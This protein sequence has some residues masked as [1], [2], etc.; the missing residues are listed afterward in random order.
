MAHPMTNEKYLPLLAQNP[1]FVDLSDQVHAELLAAAVRRTY[2]S[3][4]LIVRQ[5][6][7]AYAFHLLVEGKAKL[8]QVTANGHQVLVR[9]IVPGQ[10]TGVISVLSGFTY[11]LSIQPIGTCTTLMWPGELLAQFIERYPRIGFNAL[12]IMVI[13]NQQRQQRYQELLT[14]RVEQR[15]AQSLLRLAE[16]VGRPEGDRILLDLPLSRED[17][18]EYTGTTLFTVSRILRQWEEQGF[19]QSGRERVCLCNLPALQSIANPAPDLPIS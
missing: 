3:D 18:A 5:G 15:L 7:P 8:L 4:E 9:Y 6:D 10:Q 19:V 16:Q 13:R 14:E 12:R 17:L 1:V 2:A 11:P